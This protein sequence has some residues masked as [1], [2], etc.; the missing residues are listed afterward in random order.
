MVDYIKEEVL[1]CWEFKSLGCA[2]EN[3]KLLY[4]LCVTHI[5]HNGRQESFLFFSLTTRK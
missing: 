3:L 4:T 1:N 5:K 2:L